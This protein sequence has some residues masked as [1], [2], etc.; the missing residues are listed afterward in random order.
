MNEPGS[1][2][3][4]PPSGVASLPAGSAV[5]S[6]VL[7]T[8]LAGDE[9]GRV[10]RAAASASDAEVTIEEYLPAAIARRDADGTLGPRS[11]AQADLWAEGLQAFLQ[12]SEQMSR[13]DHPALLRVGPVWQSRGTAYRL[14]SGGEGRPLAEIVDAMTEP[15]GEAWLHG[16]LDPLLGALEAVHEAGW[17]HGN[18]RPGQIVVRA[19]G[20]PVL[21]DSGAVCGAIGARLPGSQGA[22]PETGFLAP[23]LTDASLDWPV[24]PWSDLHALA[25]VL[26][27]CIT[28]Q[29]P[30]PL[31][32]DAPL[33]TDARPALGPRALNARYSPGLVA[34]LERA[35]V[36]DPHERPQS[37]ADFRHAMEAPVMLRAVPAAPP[38]RLHPV[39][40]DVHREATAAPRAVVP[41]IRV[42]SPFPRASGSDRALAPLEPAWAAAEVPNVG[43]FHDPRIFEPHAAARE[44]GRA[45]SPAARAGG[46]SRRTRRWPWALGGMLAG[47]A[48]TGALVFVGLGPMAEVQFA[49]SLPGGES[50]VLRTPG[51]AALPD[52]DPALLPALAASG[53]LPGTP[54]PPL[55]TPGTRQAAPAVNAD[56]TAAT[57]RGGDATA[58]ERG[59]PIRTPADVAAPVA[60]TV[61]SLA[62]DRAAPTAPRSAPDGAGDASTADAGPTRTASPAET[63]E[64]ACSPRSNF[65][66]YRCMQTQCEQTRF[67]THPQCI[68]LRVRDELP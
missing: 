46:G 16:L 68:R 40:H 51:P 43:D 38:H 55:H 56:V 20:S 4:Q 28:G 2:S 36:Q 66:L 17:V 60:P 53:P 31:D 23:E 62:Q 37:T 63:P 49:L 11:P 21:L 48:L 65:A 61:D 57:S 35:L 9:F 32:L 8:A 18:V 58:R 25:Q 33:A 47:A 50:A 64:A 29:A 52:N 45:D 54:L 30:L 3:T 67:Y 59:A 41:P 13:L 5:G 15:P 26:R 24:G 7:R 14:R 42:T 19:D 6:F 10:Y 34:A 39:P 22:L 1:A 12:E 44:D 27:Y